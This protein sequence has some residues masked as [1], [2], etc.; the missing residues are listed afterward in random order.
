VTGAEKTLNV[1]GTFTPESEVVDS[2]WTSRT[3]YTFGLGAGAYSGTFKDSSGSV[4]WPGGV[5]VTYGSAPSCVGYF[6]SFDIEAP[7]SSACYDLID[8]T[9]F[10]DGPLA[11][12]LWSHTGGG[13]QLMEPGYPESG[14]GL[15]TIS[16]TAVSQGPAVFVDTRCLKTI[17]LTY[18]LSAQMYLVNAVTQTGEYCD[19]SDRFGAYRCP[20]GNLVS[21]KD[22]NFT[23][24]QFGAAA[25]VGPWY[26]GSWNAL[27]G[28][29]VVDTLVADADFIAIY[30]DDVRV[31]VEMRIDEVHLTP[32]K[33]ACPTTLNQVKNGDFEHGTYEFW[34]YYGSTTKLQMVQPGYNGSDFALSTVQRD[35]PT[36]GLTQKL[37][38]SCLKTNELYVISLRFQLKTYDGQEFVCDPYGTDTT[39]CPSASL[40]ITNGTQI[41]WLLIGSTVGPINSDWPLITGVFNAT[42]SITNSSDLQ[43][44]INK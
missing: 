39:V 6:D 27:R 41:S 21:F 18:L 42:E 9:N 13:I 38:P 25:A 35:S 32:Y 43:L 23:S 33:V 44:Y 4:V 11:A 26:N 17:G 7:N 37:N 1:T 16:R 22:N 36:V 3:L 15:Q 30:F 24:F 20:R 2:L 12:S 28:P 34:W 10:E 31:G 19:A 8:Q 40:Q 5:S 14:F 29:I